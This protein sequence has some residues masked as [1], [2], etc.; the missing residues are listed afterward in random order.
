M[1]GWELHVPADL[2]LTV[3]DRLGRAV[4]VLVDDRRD[5]GRYGVSWDGRDESGVPST[6]GIYFYRLEAGGMSKAGKMT[7]VR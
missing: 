4:K 1:I 3:H 5:A 2:R 6:S 7:L